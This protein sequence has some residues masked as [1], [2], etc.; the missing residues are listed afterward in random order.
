MHEKPIYIIT[1][2][3]S[4]SSM[5]LYNLLKNNSL[6]I[7]MIQTPCCLS[8]GC[9]R[10]IEVNEEEIQKVIELIKSNNIPI[11]AIHKKYVNKKIR[12]YSYEKIEI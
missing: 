11:R 6:N 4:N 5:L 10:S 1:F 9:S 12:R 8:A 3:S 7:Y 2:D